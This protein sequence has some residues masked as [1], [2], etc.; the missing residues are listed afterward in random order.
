MQRPALPLA[1]VALAL[2]GC[3]TALQP[4]AF[5]GQTPEMRPERFFAGETRSTGV[6][7]DRS[8]APTQRF[9]VKGTGTGL[10]DGSFRL[11]QTVTFERSASETRSWV[12]RAVDANHYAAT[13]TDAAGPVTGEAYGNL[14]HLTYPMQRPFGGEMEQWLYLQ[15]DGRTVVNEATVRV[16]GIVAAHLSERIT[17]E[18][19]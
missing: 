17:H 10:P 7:E 3:A 4:I 19:R 11:D 8:G 9:T 5:D 6:L 1:I 12:M 16:F 2:Y 13:L 14:F 15:P 18:D